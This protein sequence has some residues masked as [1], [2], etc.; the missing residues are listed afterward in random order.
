M[1]ATV[2]HQELSAIVR[3]PTAAAIV[4]A[5]TVSISKRRKPRGCLSYPSPSSNLGVPVAIVTT[6]AGI[7]SSPSPSCCSK[8][9]PEVEGMQATTEH[10]VVLFDD[11]VKN[12]LRFGCVLEY[13]VTWVI[14]ASLF[15][16]K[17]VRKRQFIK[18]ELAKNKEDI[19]TTTNHS[20]CLAVHETKLK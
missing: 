7:L 10:E 20:N 11:C 12:Q 14:S 19:I 13:E 18:K 2:Q 6:I 16:G 5:F 4:Y 17:L 3:F 8:V 15:D 9:A 1:P